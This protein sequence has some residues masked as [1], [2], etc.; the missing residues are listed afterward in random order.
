MKEVCE[1]TGLSYEG[2]KYYCNEGL[3]PNVKRDK[4]NRRIFDEHDLAWIK[5]LTCL[6][7]CKLSIDEM[8][9]Y[10]ALCLEGRKS[11]SARQKFI[12]EKRVALLK[13]IEELKESVEYIDWKDQLYEDFKSGKKKYISN[14]IKN[15]K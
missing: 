15:T 6:K 11:I 1:A 9:M 10:L 3:V 13:E 5:D 12:A 14:L 2:L 7:K 8:K 4:N